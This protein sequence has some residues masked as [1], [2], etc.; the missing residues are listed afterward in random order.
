MGTFG[1][2]LGGL[3]AHWGA[4]TWTPELILAKWSP[5]LILANSC[6]GINGFKGRGVFPGGSKTS[7]LQTV[8]TKSMV[9]SWTFGV[10]WEHLEG[11]W[12]QKHLH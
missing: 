5:K 2:T 11:V 4:L 1:S 8:A 9:L 10:F 12:K 3:W 6:I 7:L